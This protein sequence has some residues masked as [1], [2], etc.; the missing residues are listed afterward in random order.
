MVEEK[1]FDTDEK[2]EQSANVGEKEVPDVEE[3]DKALD[4]VVAID[5]PDELLSG[6]DLSKRLDAK[7]AEIKSLDEAVQK[8]IDGFK[9]FLK[10]TETHGSALAGQRVDPEEKAKKDALNLLE[11][12]G[13]NPFE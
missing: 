11:G 13:L 9:E 4:G 3:K 2:V 12:T 1:G 6:I 10:A 8:K 5:K 7:L